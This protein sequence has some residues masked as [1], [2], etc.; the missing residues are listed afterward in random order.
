MN[1][2]LT[3]PRKRPLRCAIYTRKSSEAGLE[4]EF[5]TLDA[6]RE[7]A[8]AYVESQRHDRWVA[9]A[10]R[11]DD[12]GFTGGNMR[13]PALEKLLADIRSGQ[14]DCVVVYKV[15]RLSRSLLDFSRMMAAFEKYQVEFVSITQQFNTATSMGR[16]VLNMLLSFSQFEREMI[17]E[18]TRDK[19]AATRRKGKWCGGVPI[20][21]Y[22][23]DRSVSK[24]IVNH[25]EA[26]RV[27]EIF[28]LYVK[29]RALSAVVAQLRQRG[30]RNKRRTTRKGTIRGGRPFSKTTLHHLL[31][32]VTYA[33]RLRYKQEVH[34]G[35]HEAIVNERLFDKVQRILKHNDRAGAHE[36]NG[37]EALLKGR[38]YCAACQCAMTPSFTVKGRRRYRY[39]V[40][41]RAQKQGWA[42][43]PT[44]SVSAAQ[45]QQCV[46]AQLSK[47]RRSPDLLTRLVVHGQQRQQ[48]I[49]VERLAAA[50]AHV[51]AERSAPHAQAEALRRLV[52]RIEYDGRDG[53][54]SIWLDLAQAGALAPVDPGQGGADA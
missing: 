35:E 11:Y 41:T 44:R 26:L 6:Q 16:L 13:R 54:L 20:L 33:G 5:N 28:K 18:R 25:Q 46:L 24:L 37:Y 17:S 52:T 34:E 40:C 9:L 51:E 30:W 12:G 32:N 8:E 2:Q 21:G 3:N 48:T 45:M 19:I 42:T 47:M 7:A 10:Q 38:L 29:H 1:R 22:D 39:Y 14:I 23:V 15:D 53:T 50:L 43:C 31:R 36:R 49:D 27:R 4:Q